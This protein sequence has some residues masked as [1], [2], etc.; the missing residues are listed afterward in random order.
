MPMVFMGSAV[1]ATQR[2]QFRINAGVVGDQEHREK[3]VGRDEEHFKAVFVMVM[4]QPF[5]GRH[6]VRGSIM[7]LTDEIRGDGTTRSLFKNDDGV[8]GFDND[9]FADAGQ[10]PFG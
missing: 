10:G 9:E 2:Q 3:I 6:E 8:T 7:D 4:L 1:F 5:E